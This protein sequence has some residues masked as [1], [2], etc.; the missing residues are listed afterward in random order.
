MPGPPSSGRGR[1]RPRRQGADEQILADLLF[2]ALLFGRQE[3]EAIVRI[4]LHGARNTDS[5]VRR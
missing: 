4:V 1:G 2:G 3:V 5:R